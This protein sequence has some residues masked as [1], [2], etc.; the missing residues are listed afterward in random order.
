MIKDN[1]YLFTF[2]LSY[3]LIWL[4]SWCIAKFDN[5]FYVKTNKLDYD[6]NRI[7]YFTHAI[8]NTIILLFAFSD[9]IVLFMHVRSDAF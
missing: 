4:I 2:S 1:I 7:W 8:T 9:F 6:Y 3:G 5:M